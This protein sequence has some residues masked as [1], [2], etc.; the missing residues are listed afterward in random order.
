MTDKQVGILGLLG[1]LLA[2]FVIVFLGVYIAF[3]FTEHRE[4]RQ[5]E[6]KKN[7]ICIALAEEM[8]MIAL[9]CDETSVN[10]NKMVKK[11]KESLEAGKFL[12]FMPFTEPVH[13]TP[14]MWEATIQSG[15]INILDVETI[16]QVSRYYNGGMM[17][18]TRINQIVELS[19]LYILPVYEKDGR[20]FYDVATKTVKPKYQWYLTGLERVSKLLENISATTD[21]VMSLLEVPAKE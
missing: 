14:H 1:K 16:N 19:K 5:K 10:V 4:N 2:E 7:Q 17:A 6:I 18:V 9:Q 12:P 3:L 20:I 8:K 15:G 13:F 11:Y 21:S